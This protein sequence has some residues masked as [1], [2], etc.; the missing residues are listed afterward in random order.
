[1][2]VAKTSTREFKVQNGNV[3]LTTATNTMNL[4]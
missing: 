2:D 1:M 4:K 3:R